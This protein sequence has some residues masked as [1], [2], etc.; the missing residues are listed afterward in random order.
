LVEPKPSLPWFKLI[1]DRT[2]PA[3]QKP[4]NM[5]VLDA[6]RARFESQHPEMFGPGEASECPEPAPGDPRDGAANVESAGQISRATP[7]SAG[8]GQAALTVPQTLPRA[9]D[10]DTSLAVKRRFDQRLVPSVHG[11]LAL[12]HPAWQAI[13][14]LVF[15]EAQLAGVF[16]G[17]IRRLLAVN[18]RIRPRLG[19]GL[20]RT[21]AEIVA[22]ACFLLVHQANVHDHH[23]AGGHD[24][25]TAAVVADEQHD[26]PVLHRQRLERLQ[27]L[28]IQ[29][30]GRLVPGRLGC[31]PGAVEVAARQADHQPGASLIKSTF[32]VHYPVLAPERGP[33][34]KPIAET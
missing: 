12:F 9:A 6:L 18:M 4:D 14:L 30:M 24:V 17:G 27:G 1:L 15:L 16:T 13:Q 32:P 19:P 2:E 33:D 28:D 11:L 23:R 7:A 8:S 20:I 3:W 26:S 25:Q 5:A 22:V 31:D 29:V 10:P 21:L 34:G